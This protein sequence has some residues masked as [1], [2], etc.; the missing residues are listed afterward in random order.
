ML[1]FEPQMNLFECLLIDLYMTYVVANMRGFTY[2]QM[3]P[4]KM[5]IVLWKCE[6]GIVNDYLLMPL[7]EC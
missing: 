4:S 7:R 3:N 6:N 1:L 5:L 2:V